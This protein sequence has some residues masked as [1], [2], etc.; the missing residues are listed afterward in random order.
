LHLPHAYNVQ[1]SVC[2]CLLFYLSAESNRYIIQIMK[3]RPHTGMV[4][5]GVAATLCLV[6]ILAR[7]VPVSAPDPTPA[8][9]ELL[10]NA[11][12]RSPDQIGPPVL[13][14]EDV[15]AD[16][17]HT[18]KAPE[19]DIAAMTGQESDQPYRPMHTNAAPLLFA[20]ADESVRLYPDEPWKLR[21]RPIQMREGVF[22]SQLADG[23]T[24][25]LQL[26]LFGD[27]AHVVV[28]DHV[29]TSPVGITSLRG[30]IEG[31]DLY[32]FVMTKADG[33]YRGELT[34]MARGLLYVIQYA[35]TAGGHVITEY[36]P[37]KM[38]PRICGTCQ[39][40]CET[41]RPDETK[42]KGEP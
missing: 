2:D 26:D 3:R 13:P 36:E 20:S 40:A 29:R 17:A 14:G 39:A 11:G 23:E 42:D 7:N 25:R 10:E 27:L 41:H 37:A 18:D 12:G 31:E 28:I 15:A 1:F 22:P 24:I 33:M 34:D 5:A 35:E 9:E 30:R 19:V 21:S 38:P 4:V 16:P 32:T 6:W 8:Q